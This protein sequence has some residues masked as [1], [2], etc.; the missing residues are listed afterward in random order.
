MVITILVMGLI[1]IPAS[2]ASSAAQK[3]AHATATTR[4]FATGGHSQARAIPGFEAGADTPRAHASTRPNL[5]AFFQ[6]D[7]KLN[8]WSCGYN[9]CYSLVYIF[10]LKKILL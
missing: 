4:A 1:I 7:N 6:Q 5:E 8:H 3:A 9:Y 2:A 10:I